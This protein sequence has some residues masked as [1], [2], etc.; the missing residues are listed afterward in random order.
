MRSILTAAAAMAVLAAFGP[1]ATEAATVNISTD[2]GRLHVSEHGIRTRTNKDGVTSFYTAVYGSHIL[3]MEVMATYTDGTSEKMSFTSMGGRLAGAIGSGMS[4]TYERR[5]WI[6]STTKNL[7]SLVIDAATGNA[8]FDILRSPS[9]GMGDDTYGTSYGFGYRTSGGDALEG[10]INAEYQNGVIVRG[11]ARGKDTFT[12]LAMDYTGLKGGGL[13]GTTF[14]HS[15]L[16]SIHV[17][18]DLTPV[19]LPAGLPLLAGGLF[20][21]APLRNRKR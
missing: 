14:F 19:P 10:A 12:T 21:L 11:H 8:V 20:L 5:D 16:D 2:E 18:G 6:V 1:T 7:A 13:L 17:A 15:D 4:L 3:G 9:D